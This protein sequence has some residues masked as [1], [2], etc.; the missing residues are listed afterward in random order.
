MT[1][2]DQAFMEWAGKRHSWL[3][4]K[5]FGSVAVRHRGM[6]RLLVKAC[7]FSVRMDR[8]FW[9]TFRPITRGPGR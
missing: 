8:Y 6:R 2:D 3:Y 4:R 9:I 1:D 7:A 5:A